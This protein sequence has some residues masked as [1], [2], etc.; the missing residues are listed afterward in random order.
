VEVSTAGGAS[1]GGTAYP[2]D[3]GS[4][5]STS[6][7]Q[8]PGGFTGVNVAS[9]SITWQWSLSP[10]GKYYQVMAATGGPVSSLLGPAVTSYDEYGLLANTTYSRYVRVS[11]CGNS[12]DSSAAE[13]AT[14]TSTQAAVSPP[15]LAAFTSSITVR[16]AACPASPEA[17][18]CEGYRLEASSTNFGAL[19]PGGVTESST[20]YSRAVSTLT[21]QAPLSNT[22]WYFR[23]FGLNHAGSTGTYTAL[24]STSTLAQAPVRLAEDFLAVHFTSVTAQWAALPSGAAEGYLVA[25]SS[26][27]FGALLPGGVVYSSS[28]PDVLVSTLTVWQPPG[29]DACKTHY[30]RLASL[31]WNGAPNYV[32]VGSTQNLRYEVLVSTHELTIGSVNMDTEIVISTS[33][34]VTNMACP[35]TFRI[36]AATVTAGSPWVISTTSGTDTFTLQAVFNAVEPTL[37]DFEDID[38]LTDA[39]ADSTA[40]RFAMGQTGVSVPYTGTRLLWFKLGLPRVTSTLAD[41]TIRVTVFAVSP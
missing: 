21:I 33:Y 35:A 23:V 26:T 40:A 6:T 20:T 24:G 34:I 5:S 38:K 28:T 25:A 18:S 39:P 22:T 4:F 1:G 11:G 9:Y 17:V 37:A 10:A 13:L 27:D 36:M 14:L 19:L 31:N 8:P 12:S 2:G 41:Q 29:L 16:W 3:G 15:A 7:F 32:A 30:F